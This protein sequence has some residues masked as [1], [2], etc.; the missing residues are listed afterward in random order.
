V[1]VADPPA[2]LSPSRNAPVDKP[3]AREWA[4]HMWDGCDFFAWMRIL[5]HN[6]FSVHPAFWFIALVVTLLSFFHTFFR[7]VQEIVFGRAIRRTPMRTP[8]LI[9][10]G[11]WRTGTTLLHEMLIRDE[12]H[13][14]PTSYECFAPHH[15]LLSEP[16]I[17]PWFRFL[18]PAHRPMDNM[19]AGFNHPQEDEFALCMLGI[20]S[21]YWAFAF[22]NHNPQ[23]PAYFDLTGLPRRALNDWKKAFVGFL[24]RVHFKNPG[25]RLVLKSP[26]HT[27]RIPVL[28]DLFPDALFVHIVRDPKVVIPSTINLWK[29]LSSTQ[30]FQIPRFAGLEEIILDTYQKMYD[31]LEKTRHSIDP[32]RFY[33]IRY[34]DL[35]ADPVVEMQK[36]Y[37]HLGLGGFERYQ[38]ALESFWATQIGY[39]TNRYELSDDMRGRVARCCSAVIARFRYDEVSG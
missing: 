22:P 26:P 37:E 13:S 25:K 20:P 12:R 23:N 29:A 7:I 3:K 30:G 14:Y 36:V 11:H 39:K 9:I 17:T 15:F 19:P 10:L 31:R 24:Q 5:S 34:E 21:P 32:S 33:E 6:R 18:M 1:A 28:L 8:P 2:Q 38:P 35:I 27:C 16:W 4:A